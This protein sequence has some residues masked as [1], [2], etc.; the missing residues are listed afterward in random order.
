MPHSYVRVAPNLK[1]EHSVVIKAVYRIVDYQVLTW[2]VEQ[3]TETRCSGDV[4]NSKALLAE[5]FKLLGNS[6]YGKIMCVIYRND[7]K[8][9]KWVL[10]R[11][12]RAQA[13]V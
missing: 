3:V 13:S 9:V 12:G 10:Q 2:F 11:S 7:E 5:E 8:V 4:A 6:G 1:V